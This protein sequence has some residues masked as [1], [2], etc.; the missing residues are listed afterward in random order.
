[1]QK[2]NK[3]VCKV[4]DTLYIMYTVSALLKICLVLIDFCGL[5]R[6][7]SL[8]RW[9]NSL[10]TTNTALNF[11]RKKFKLK[12]K[13]TTMKIFHTLWESL[14]LK[15]ACILKALIFTLILSEFEN[16]FIFH[17]ARFNWDVG[18]LFPALAPDL[19]TS[20]TFA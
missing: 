13:E 18:Y 1:M 9:E 11:K 15:R 5:R 7:E 16:I 19:E 4:Y 20:H 14:D 12:K 6:L 8:S 17:S 10:K 2:I 3:C